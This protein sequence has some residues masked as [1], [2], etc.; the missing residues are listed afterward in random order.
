M[1]EKLSK[2][3]ITGALTIAGSC[4]VLYSRSLWDQCWRYL[5]EASIWTRHAA[6]VKV[7]ETVVAGVPPTVSVTRSEGSGKG[8]YR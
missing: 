3:S 6:V 5:E 7:V 1:E 8:G 4:L 2:T